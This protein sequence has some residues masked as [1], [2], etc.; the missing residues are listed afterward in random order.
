MPA[1]ELL[2]PTKC[3]LNAINVR[4][5]LHGKEHVPAVDLKI[6]LDAS[7]AILS[8]FDTGLKEALYCRREPLDDKQE[9]LDGVDPIT[10]LPN[11]RFPKL[12]TPLKWT[13]A[14]S[15]YEFTVD[16][17]L[18]GVSNIVVPGVQVNNFG[19]TPREGGTCE[20]GF[21]VQV[22]GIDETV[23][24]RLAM[25]CQ[26]EVTITLVAPK[27]EDV[28]DSLKPMESPFLNQD[29]LDANKGDGKTAWPFPL[30]PEQALE[31]SVAG[32]SAA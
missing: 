30:T 2:T 23:I 13:L 27:L 9:S 25:L 5:E 15:G 16:F 29:A 22:S 11:L 10:D 32:D 31:G 18:G 1:F 7:N 26:H 24:G 8:Q 28:Q 14:G 3:K 12:D 17:G 20:V 4:S 21:R 6:T 19:L